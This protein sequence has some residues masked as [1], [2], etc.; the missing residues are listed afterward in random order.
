MPSITRMQGLTATAALAL[1]LF[2]CSDGEVKSDLNNDG[3]PRVLTVTVSSEALWLVS[4][5]S[6][7]V[8]TYCADPQVEKMNPNYCPAG[9][10]DSGTIQNAVDDALPLGWELR[11]I[12]N[13]LLDAEGVERLLPCTDDNHDGQCGSE[14]T[15]TFG[16]DGELLVT[17][18]LIDTQPVTLRCAG[19]DI[20]YDGYYQP[21][22][23]HLTLPGGPALVIQPL[24]P[25]AFAATGSNCEVTVKSDV[26]SKQSEGMS[27]G[28]PYGFQIAPLDVIATNPM[29]GAQVPGSVEIGL[30]FN[31]PIDGASL[32]GTTLEVTDEMGDPHDI[33]RTA[34]GDVVAV[35]SNEGG[36]A[37]NTNYTLTINSGIRDIKGGAYADSYTLNFTTL[38]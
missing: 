25:D 33:V 29:E 22:G 3:P 34:F 38:P 2:G 14:D 4:A 17:G 26:Q 5:D 13:E 19:Q 10:E 9:L 32:D 16:S 18:S 27:N 6:L 1:A 12:F 30:L 24:F 28:G 7:E 36:F 15:I 35:R 8:A 37:A 31:A 11:V 23:S 20:P 21:A